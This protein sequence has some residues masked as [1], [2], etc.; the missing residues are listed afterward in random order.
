MWSQSKTLLINNHTIEYTKHQDTGPITQPYKSVL[1][2]FP[3]EMHRGTHYPD[4]PACQIHSSH[5]NIHFFLTHTPLRL[6]SPHLSREPYISQLDIP[7]FSQAPNPDIYTFIL[8]LTHTPQIHPLSHIC[9]TP[10]H[11]HFHTH[12]I[13]IIHSHIYAPQIYL[14]LQSLYPIKV[15]LTESPTQ[16][17]HTLTY[18]IKIHLNLP[19]PHLGGLIPVLCVPTFCFKCTLSKHF[20]SETCTLQ[21]HHTQIQHLDIFKVSKA[22]YMSTD[23]YTH[24]HISPR[25]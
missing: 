5:I 13:Y 15:T 12:P 19:P 1:D 7:T 4:I 9:P 22:K 2:I 21:K 8:L 3:T 18:S 23:T 10:I 17:A 20:Q 24:K 16:H 11:P 14:H 6:A 25:F